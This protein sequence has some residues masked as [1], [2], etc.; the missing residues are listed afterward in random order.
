MN[1]IYRGIIPG[2][3]YEQSLGM[4]TLHGP[5]LCTK[6]FASCFDEALLGSAALEPVRR[7]LTLP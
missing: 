4:A 1:I 6:R 5:R 7:S 3:I 2:G